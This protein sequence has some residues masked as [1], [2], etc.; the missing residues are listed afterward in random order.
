MIEYIGYIISYVYQI[1]VILFVLK[2]FGFIK[3]RDVP[4]KAGESSGEKDVSAPPPNMLNALFEKMG[5]MIQ[6]MQEQMMK[7]EQPKA[8]GKKQTTFGDDDQ[9]DEIAAV[10]E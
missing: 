1:A 7:P 4:Q 9:L 8:G 2:E 3:G 5:P 10:D 6:G